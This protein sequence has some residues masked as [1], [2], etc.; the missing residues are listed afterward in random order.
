MG[1]LETFSQSLDFAKEI[2]GRQACK[3]L[4]NANHKFISHNKRE[5]S[6]FIF[7][8]NKIFRNVYLIG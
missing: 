1:L 5:R 6:P 4:Q 7:Y 2:L 3:N 8:P